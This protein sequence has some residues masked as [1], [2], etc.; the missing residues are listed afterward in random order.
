MSPND[1]NN[2]DKNPESGGRPPVDRDLLISRVVDDAASAADWDQLR[3]LA[4]Y[5]PSVWRELFE[6][7]RAQAELAQAVEQAI[8]IADEIDAPLEHLPRHGMRLRFRQVASWGGWA[9]AAS[10]AI[11]FVAPNLT[12]PAPVIDGGNQAGIVP[13]L[14]TNQA[15]G[16]TQALGPYNP[17]EFIASPARELQL[18]NPPSQSPYLTDPYRLASTRQERAAEQLGEMPDRVL[19]EVRRLPD[20]K[21]E[22][23]YVRRLI[24]RAVVDEDSLYKVKPDDAGIERTVPYRQRR[25]SSGPI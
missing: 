3:S 5:D 18:G 11:F 6:A 10:V 1:H 17:P 21:L 4:E 23:V 13:P 22:L 12:G 9:V 15:N 24:E 2:T 14:G 25:P 20:G 8:A 16:S 19:L 7:Q